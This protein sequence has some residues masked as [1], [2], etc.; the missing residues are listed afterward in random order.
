MSTVTARMC[1][2]Y[3]Q[4]WGELFL[5]VSCK[6]CHV[7]PIVISQPVLVC[8]VYVHPFADLAVPVCVILVSPLL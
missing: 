1:V 4:F 2:C 6:I 3:P 8:F 7:A 5:T